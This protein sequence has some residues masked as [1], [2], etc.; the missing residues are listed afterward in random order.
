[1]LTLFEIST[2]EMWPD[3]MYMAVDARG[4]GLAGKRDHNPSAALYFVAF[5]FCTTFFIMNLYVGAVIEKF[6]KI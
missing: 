5:I 3:Y 6:N 1:M 2:L 4:P